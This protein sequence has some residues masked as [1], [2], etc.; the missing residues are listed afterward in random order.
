ML[1]YVKKWKS[2]WNPAEMSWIEFIQ[3]LGGMYRS[4]WE[5]PRGR[6]SV[7]RPP[8]PAPRKI[9]RRRQMRSMMYE[10]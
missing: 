9:V 2:Q 8:K 5:L 4:D 7:A 6:P 1:L 3:R 10:I